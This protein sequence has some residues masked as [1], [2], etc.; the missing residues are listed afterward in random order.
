VERVRFQLDEHVTHAIARAVARRG[1]AITTATESRVVGLP[2]DQLLARCRAEGRV[3]VTQDRD[4]LRLHRQ[5]AP[6]AGIVCCE[7]GSRSIGEIVEFL[8]L[9]ADIYVPADM[10]GRVEFVR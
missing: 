1:V 2:D 10:V 3:L 4:F 9:V 5:G 8:L 7:Q 6:H